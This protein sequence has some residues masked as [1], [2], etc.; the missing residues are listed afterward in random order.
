MSRIPEDATRYYKHTYYKKGDGCFAMYFGH[1]G[2]TES[3]LISNSKL[4]HIGVSCV[5]TIP[6]R[7][8]SD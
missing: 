7:K 3:L 4:E 2:W 6:Q 5:G 1:T 8:N